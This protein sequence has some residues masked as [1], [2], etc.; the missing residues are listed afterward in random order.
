MSSVNE[1][2]SIWLVLECSRMFWNVRMCNKAFIRGGTY[3]GLNVFSMTSSIFTQKGYCPD[4]SITRIEL[5]C[6]GKEISPIISTLQFNLS[7]E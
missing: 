3:I 4:N 1:I 6:D 2:S 5:I 7:K